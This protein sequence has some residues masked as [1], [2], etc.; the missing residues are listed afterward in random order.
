[1][2]LDHF[3][4]ILFD[5]IVLALRKNTVKNIEGIIQGDQNNNW[6][7]ANDVVNRLLIAVINGGDWDVLLRDLT[8]VVTKWENEKYEK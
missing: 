3:S 2:M 5:Q 6:A 1:M 4:I 7:T 8:D